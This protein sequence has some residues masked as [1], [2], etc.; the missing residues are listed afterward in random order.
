M[1]AFP[2]AE[3]LSVGTGTSRT[4]GRSAETSRMNAAS[5]PTRGLIAETAPRKSQ[6]RD[7][8]RGIG[9]GTG[10]PERHSRVKRL[11][12]RPG[13]TTLDRL[14]PACFAPVQPIAEPAPRRRPLPGEF[15]VQFRFRSSYGSERPCSEQT[16]GSPAPRWSAHVARMPL[17]ASFA[18]CPA[19]LQW[20]ARISC[21]VSSP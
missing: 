11:A 13:K 21:D 7:G 15:F 10:W 16:R 8:G 1:S 2:L 20:Q 6:L 17:D 14:L 18:R 9:F 19:H 12:M 5:A 3:R 4:I